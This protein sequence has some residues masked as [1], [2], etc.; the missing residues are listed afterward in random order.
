MIISFLLGKQIAAMLL[1]VLM[2]FLVVRFRILR[3]EDSRVLSAIALYIV[4]PCMTLDAF[5]VEFS[6]EKLQG[7]FLTVGAS[8]LCFLVTI[9]LTTAL[10]RP[11]RLEPVEQASALYSNGGNL[12]IPIVSYVLGPEW[13]L[14]TSGFIAV[15]TALFW[16]HCV[17]VIGG[18]RHVRLRDILLRVNILAIVLGVVLFASGMRFPEVPRMAVHAV[19]ITIGP[20]CMIVTGMLIGGMDL[21]RLAVYRRLPLIVFMRLFLYPAVVLFVYHLS[22]IECLAE[23]GRTILLITFLAV[24]APGASTVVNMAQ[25]YRSN[26]EYASLINVATTLLCVI[27]MPVMVWF[28]QQG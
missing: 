11:L 13:I 1:M 10:H 6:P 22:G 16:T 19:G 12:I 8:V 27:S 23:N 7:L 5:Q 21:R 15:Q 3:P 26:G 20:I 24:A 14:F 17:S 4:S 18:R 25:V 28:F 9:P 2:G